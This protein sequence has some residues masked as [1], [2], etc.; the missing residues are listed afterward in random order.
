MLRI[1]LS[2][3]PFY[4][5]RAVHSV[6]VLLGLV[7]T[8]IMGVGVY[9]LVAL[10]RN[11]TELISTAEANES[12]AADI[13]AKVATMRRAINDHNLKEL[14][15][16][17]S[18]ANGLIDRR[19]FSWTQFFNRLEGTLPPSVMLTSVRPEIEP[20]SI[21][22]LLEVVGLKVEHINTFIE[23]LEATGAFFEILAREEELTDDGMYRA[24]IRGQYLLAL[25]GSE[26]DTNHTSLASADNRARP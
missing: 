10:S 9:H 4:N 2:T 11:S 1:N 21:N 3:R 13:A 20:D 14:T 18:E 24:S 26:A 17:A 12:Q 5:E 23:Q 7:A 25:D 6:L 22:V 8:T 15:G 16:A 19:G